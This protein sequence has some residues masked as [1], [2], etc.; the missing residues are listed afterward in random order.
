M[1]LS[2]VKQKEITR[3]NPYNSKTLTVDLESCLLSPFLLQ[4]VQAEVHFTSSSPGGIKAVESY[5]S[6]QT[7]FPCQSFHIFL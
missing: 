5:E 7:V 4:D 6:M 2:A 1:K 3:R